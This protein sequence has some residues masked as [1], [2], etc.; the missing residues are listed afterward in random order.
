MTVKSESLALTTSNQ[1]LLTCGAG[2][3][4]VV[5]GLAAH[6]TSGSERTVTLRHYQAA[7]ARTIDHVIEVPSTAPSSAVWPTKI[8]MQPSDTLGAKTDATTVTLLWSYDQDAGAD[9]LASGLTPRAAPLR[10]SPMR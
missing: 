1:T 5:F 6:N 8:A 4:I 7:N 10:G 2:L 9:P 3:E